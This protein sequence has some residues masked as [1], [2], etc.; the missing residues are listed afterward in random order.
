MHYIKISNWSNFIYYSMIIV[1]VLSDI[2]L[3]PP[4]QTSDN[5]ML[6]PCQNFAQNFVE[7]LYVIEMLTG[8][9]TATICL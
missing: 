7:R 6:L 8:E 4:R 2:N 5:I 1:W 9:N 3:T